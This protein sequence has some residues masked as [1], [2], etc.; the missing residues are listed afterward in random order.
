MR[1]GWRHLRFMLLQSPLHVTLI[2]G[3]LLVLLGLVVGGLLPAGSSPLLGRNGDVQALIL[4]ARLALAGFATLALG[5][6]ARFLGRRRRT[7]TMAAPPRLA[8]LA[9]VNRTGG[10]LPVGAPRRAADVHGGHSNCG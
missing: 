9:D 5:I 1:D 6:F 3:A 10:G 2:P 4:G 7:T 8:A